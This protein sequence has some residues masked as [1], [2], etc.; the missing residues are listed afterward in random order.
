[1]SI[2]RN[3]HVALSILGVKGHYM[4]RQ[5]ADKGPDVGVLM[6]LV[7][8]ELRTSCHPAFIPAERCKVVRV[9]SSLIRKHKGL[10]TFLY[11]F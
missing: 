7:L 11:T 1:M 4:E 10:Y 5:R 3:G 6:L 8:P 2:L 9:G